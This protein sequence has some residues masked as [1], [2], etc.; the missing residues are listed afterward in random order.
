VTTGADIAFAN[1]GSV[2]D[3]IDAGEITYGDV[4]AVYPFKNTI[5]VIEATGQEILD[6]L[7]WASRGVPGENGGF[8]QTS[9]LT[10]EIDTSVESGC[11]EDDAGIMTGIKGDERRVGNV[12]VGGK[13]I[14]PDEKYTVAGF[15]YI[16]MNDGDGQTAFKNSKVIDPDVG[17]D[18]ELFK[19]YLKEELGGKTGEEYEDPTGQ[20]RIII[21]E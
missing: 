10:Y 13:P 20:E 1:G 5:C 3:G 7:E 19:K 6:G 11:E 12:R 2:R 4:L 14:D 8:L 15:V 9:G 17:S 21:K 18:A 16:F